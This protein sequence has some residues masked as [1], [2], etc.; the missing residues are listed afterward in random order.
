MSHQGSKDAVPTVL[1]N[2]TS[3]FLALLSFL[4]RTCCGILVSLSLELRVTN[5]K[6]ER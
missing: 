6:E 3:P 1:S 5:N 4:S 2:G